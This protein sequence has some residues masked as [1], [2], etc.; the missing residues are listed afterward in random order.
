MSDLDPVEFGRAVGGML[1]EVFAPLK[2]R[3]DEVELHKNIDADVIDEL[4]TCMERVEAI[5]SGKLVKS[6]AASHV[7]GSQIHDAVAQYLAT[8]PPQRDLEYLPATHEIRERWTFG[9]QTQEF[10]FP[11]GGIHDGGFWRD[12]MNAKAMHV[13]TNNG[14]AWVC[15]KDTNAKPCHENAIDWRLFA[16]KGKDA[17]TEVS[18]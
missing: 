11:A 17:T 5:E 6:L 14:S 13:Y 1:R 2:K 15:L 12:G 3:L 18:K 7:D 8:N 9:G 4:A 10:L 16:R